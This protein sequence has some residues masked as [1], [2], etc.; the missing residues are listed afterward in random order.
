MVSLLTRANAFDGVELAA[1]PLHLSAHPTIERWLFR[2]DPAA[3]DAIGSVLGLALPREACRAV[4]AGTTH[5]LWLG[6]D[7]WL[8]FSETPPLV[9]GPAENSHAL[10]DIGHRQAGFRVA[11]QQAA[12][13]LNAGCPL[14]LDLA[15]FPVGA[16]TRTVFGK[17]EIVLWRVAP[18]M[19]HVEAARSFVPYVVALLREAARGVV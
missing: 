6:P 10:V 14:D 13:A 5:A 19:F 4:S 3:V 7:E 18:E 16:C 11:G 1:P 15:V 12:T 2:G 9:P 8:L 17:A